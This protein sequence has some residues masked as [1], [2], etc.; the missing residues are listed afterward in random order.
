MRSKNSDIED[1]EDDVKGSGEGLSWRVYYQALKERLWLIILFAIAGVVYA[2]YQSNKAVPIYA[3][4]A[5]LQFESP[6]RIMPLDTVQQDDLS[7]EQSLN[8]LIETL[9]SR[10]MLQRVAIRLKLDRD[11]VFL[12][13]PAGRDANPLDVVV[14]RLQGCVSSGV[15]GRTRLIDIRAEHTDPE[16]ARKLADGVAEEYLRFTIE[17]RNRSNQMANQML[18]EEATRLKEK[19]SRSQLA[20]QEFRERTGLVSLEK[21]Q[22]IVVTRFKQLNERLNEAR[23][24]RMQLEVDMA[25]ALKGQSNAEDLLK[26]PS[27][28]QNA[29]VRLA[30]ER[31]AQEEANLRAISARYREK[32]PRHIDQVARVEAA[33]REL[34]AAAMRAA[35][36]MKEQYET[37]KE[38]ESRIEKEFQ[39][40]EK[41]TYT[42]GKTQVEYDGLK[43]DVEQD[44]AV[45]NGVL[46]SLKQSD[47]SKGFETDSVEIVEPAVASYAPV[48]PDK[49]KILLQWSIGGIVLGLGLTLG[50]HFLDNSIK[51]VAE[52]ETMTGLPVLT[53]I[54]AKKTS[55]RKNPLPDLEIVHQKNSPVSESFRTL[56]SAIM[57]LGRFDERRV[58]M[59]TSALPAEGKTFCASNFAVSLAQQGLKTVL[60]DC[61]LRKPAIS[62]VFLGK[63]APIGVSDVLAGQCAL[64][65]VLQSTPVADLDVLPAGSRSPNP[66]ELLSGKSLPRL[67]RDLLERYDKVVI[68][69]APIM[70]VSDTLV[71]APHVDTICLVVRSHK[72]PAYAVMRASVALR[73]T[74]KI[75]AGIV[76]NRMPAAAAGQYYYYSSSHGERKV[77]GSA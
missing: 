66:S 53:A 34:P 7:N 74:D 76:L 27:I 24:R 4:R 52:A 56:R 35:A 69:S 47:V 40:Q 10:T 9:N 43:R 29:D 64:D 5:V 19:V 17:T 67:I 8:T 45:F 51:A 77:Y 71:V 2:A 36:T 18:M 70:A 30:Q 58:F 41:D 42:L 25:G 33:K 16:T 72:T 3:S 14:G 13:R 21:D 15:R 22:D 65:E 28:A 75:P 54:I 11:F 39:D 6:R 68:D 48:R 61:D 31:W 44:I 49:R 20:L 38:T 46:S 55:A 32:H 63:A 1:D 57:L 12:P 37:A 59:F 23:S 50:L 60:V 73:K 62:E 26:V